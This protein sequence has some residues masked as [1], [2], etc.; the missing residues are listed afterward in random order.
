MS[1]TMEYWQLKMRRANEHL[2]AL[3]AE[4]ARLVETCLD[5][6][7]GQEKRDG[8]IVQYRRM[9]GATA[10]PYSERLGMLLGDFLG[11]LRSSLDH[12][13]SIL[14]WDHR[15]EILDSAEFPIFFCKKDYNKRF[16]G[17]AHKIRGVPPLAA[18]IIEAL[19]PYGRGDHSEREADPLW[20][21]HKL[22]NTDKHSLTPWMWM[23]ALRSEPDIIEMRGMT[24]ISF[25]VFSNEGGI[26]TGTQFSLLTARVTA[27]QASMN[28]NDNIEFA[29]CFDQRTIV[30]GH[31]VPDVCHRL[32]DYVRDEVFPLFEQFH[33]S[34]VIVTAITSGFEEVD[35]ADPDLPWRWREV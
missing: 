6:I 11:N 32:R 34:P 33:K 9:L 13:V 10:A 12:L 28:M 31:R 3:D 24:K 17:A 19:Q 18:T 16:G 14:T 20:V 2:D 15:G 7:I 4:C 1:Q 25:E 26:N 27:E 21:L 8:D 23:R 5:G 35:P 22:V 29:V 30:P